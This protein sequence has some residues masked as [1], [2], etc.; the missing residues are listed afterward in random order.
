M[1][2]SQDDV[3]FASV[4]EEIPKDVFVIGIDPGKTGGLVTIDN[5]YIHAI[6]MLSEAD[7]CRHIFTKAYEARKRTWMFLEKAFM[8]S[9]QQG[10]RE[11]L[12]RTGTLMGALYAAAVE[13]EL[14]EID[15]HNWQE[16]FDFDKRCTI[17]APY[18]GMDARN[19]ASIKAQRRNEFKRISREL[20]SFLFP[21]YKKEL[22][23]GKNDG[24]SDALLITLYGLHSRLRKI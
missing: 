12:T 16:L 8:K 6:R 11:Y 19:K 21:A 7:S 10:M 1:Y 9:G 20:A 5:G 4:L 22:S 18:K 15:P 13:Y 17:P 24:I 3:K 14:F 23:I 2:I